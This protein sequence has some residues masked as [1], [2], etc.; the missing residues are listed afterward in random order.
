MNNEE[1]ILSMLEKQG[2]MLNSLVAGQQQTNQRLDRIE[3]DVQFL[4]TDIM[5]IS[6]LLS[7]I[8]MKFDELDKYFKLM[9]QHQDTDFDSLQSVNEKLEL[10]TAISQD[11]E[12]KFQKIKAI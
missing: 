3:A 11:H 2:E 7:T 12:K 4:K 5:G 8:G 9:S 6:F 10:L 1:R